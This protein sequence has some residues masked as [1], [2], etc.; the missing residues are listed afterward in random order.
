MFE[1]R[2]YENILS[3]V[4][5]VG[6]KRGVDIRPGS[7]FYDSASGVCV[8]IASYY[9]D[10]KTVF[11]LV[12]VST[13][14]DE[15]LDDKGA[16]FHTFRIPATSARYEFKYEGSRPPVGWRFFADGQYFTLKENE[17]K[18]YLESEEP[19]IGANSIIPGTAAV[20]T[21]TFS[22][23]QSS[24]FG[25]MEEPGTNIE[26]DESFRQRIREKI[27]GPAE[28]GNR[29]HF[30][31]WCEEVSGGIR[32]R[33]L[34]LAAGEN[35]VVGIIIGPDGIPAAD[36]VVERVQLYV[37]P[38]TK[39]LQ[40]EFNGKLI[41][42]GDGTGNGKANIGAHFAAVAAEA[43]PISIAFTAVLSSGATKEQIEQE[44]SEAIINH[45]KDLALN[46]PDDEK[47]VVRVS[48]IGAMLFAL[49]SLID[50]SKLTLNGEAANIEVENTQ[51]AVLE[52][53]LVSE[54][55]R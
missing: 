21:K 15:Y 12:F 24:A 44:A 10:L 9:A 5:A 34:P 51:V 35:T 49:S 6:T 46:T 43:L 33:I 20:T 26:D 38:I 55:I 27:S 47:I 53:V 36:T 48:T 13:A 40:K 3:E 4:L 28:N 41:A 32:A 11:D 2:T 25:E 22:G 52:G 42:F 18:L 23:L 7:I 39:G 17:S 31:T 29:Q 16:E 45:L 14:V 1:D 54:T 37:D 8:K 30:K 19:G 50:Y